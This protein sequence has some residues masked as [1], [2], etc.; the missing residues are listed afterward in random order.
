MI[1][2]RPLVEART[3]GE[4]RGC[5]PE[6]A[7]C[8]RLQRCLHVPGFLVK[9]GRLQHEFLQFP[10][11]LTILAHGRRREFLRERLLDG[12]CG[13]RPVLHFEE[14]LRRVPVE[15]AAHITLAGQQQLA[16]LLVHLGG[17]AHL[18]ALPITIG[19]LLPLAARGVERGRVLE[20]AR[21][22]E[23]RRGIVVA[24]LVA[25][26]VRG[27]LEFARFD[28]VLHRGVV[29]SALRAQFAGA[30]EIALLR[31]LRGDLF[32]LAEQARVWLRRS[33]AGLRSRL[34][35]HPIRGC[36]RK[37][38]ARET[39][40][41]DGAAGRHSHQVL[42]ELRRARRSERELHPGIERHHRRMLGSE[43]AAE[44]PCAERD[45]D[46]R[47]RECDRADHRARIGES[48]GEAEGLCR[49]LAGAKSKEAV[50]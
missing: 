4:L 48:P 12:L 15:L 43:R 40:R 24:I 23:Q 44:R 6:F 22:H 38:Q 37:H 17:D 14:R 33:G 31:E 3:L 41:E 18:A 36:G 50:A 13:A 32:R 28:E 27:L 47:K 49:L 30:D 34:L 2:R 11:F 29:Q 39:Q 45:A 26:H 25:A 1:L 46:E 35:V 16:G 42:C 5:A 9:L 8:E 10:G 7:V 20:L 19:R 21:L